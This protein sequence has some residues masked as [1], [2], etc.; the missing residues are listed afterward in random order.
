MASF[1]R[2]STLSRLDSIAEG[3]Y[4]LFLGS[5]SSSSSSGPGKRSAMLPLPDVLASI[6][7]SSAVALS[8]AEAN[9][10]LELLRELAP[11]FVST[12][13]VGGR[14]WACLEDGA[15]L[16]RVREAVKRELRG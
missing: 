11:G 5:S 4:M 13:T 14:Q 8:R 9:E 6:A 15:Q 16:K 10:A 7:K 2:R 12:T 1:K 3:L